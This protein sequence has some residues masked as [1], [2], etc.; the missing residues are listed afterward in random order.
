M[1]DRTEPVRHDETG[2]ARDE[3]EQRPLQPLLG[4]RIDRTG[5]LIEDEQPRVG[6]QRAG[7]ADELA[8]SG[9]QTRAP[10]ADLG[11]QAARQCIQNI[12]TIEPC[13]CLAH[14]RLGGPG[15]AQPDVVEHR[16][17]EQM[18]RLLHHAGLP[19]QGTAGQRADLAPVD[20]DSAAGGQMKLG[21]QVDDRALATAGVSHEGDRAPGRRG[22]AHVAQHE[23]A[24]VVGERDVAELDRHARRRSDRPAGA[25]IGQV[26][27][28]GVVLPV[29]LGVE[30][31]E[32]PLRPRHRDQSLV[33]LVADDL[34]RREEHVG[35][36]EKLNEVAHL[37]VAVERP[38]AAEHEQNGDEE[39]A[40]QLEQRH[41]DRRGA[42]QGDVVPGV[43]VEQTAEQ[44]RVRLLPHKTLRDAHAVDRLGQRRRHPAEAF[45]R[46][47]GILAQL[48]PE[49]PVERPED[50]G[51]CDHDEEHHPVAPRHD[52]GREEHL[53]GL[54]AAHEQHVLD[55]DPERLHVGGDAAQDAPELDTVEERHRHALDVRKEVVAQGVNHRLAD[56]LGVPLAEVKHA[57][58]HGGEQTEDDEVPEQAV[59]VVAGNRT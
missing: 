1:A 17:A 36:E 31:P 34:D 53:A 39:L 5:R 50:R 56:L 10:L 37:H 18:V 6:Q 49:V 42:R 15:A 2:P 23:P 30:Q 58:G 28:G 51:Q 48:D 4:Q 54:N 45:L 24:R 13:R 14:V 9:R 52:H 26:D 59:R 22:E 27:R 20:V 12:D 57:V 16:A 3:P 21:H 46:G 25:R 43:I 47:A 8:L 41:E 38:P 40:V 19:V 11:V 29:R 44:T 55:A 32:H 35:E 33:V 7:E